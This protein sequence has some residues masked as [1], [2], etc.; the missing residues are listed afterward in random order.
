MDVGN[1][2]GIIIQARFASTRLPGKLFRTFYEEKKLIDVFLDNIINKAGKGLP[3]VLATSVNKK[4]DLF[5]QVA[6]NHKVEFFRGSE[7]DVLQRTIDAAKKFGIS[8]VIRVCADNPV[9]D[10]EGTLKL[11]KSHHGNHA[12]YSG[13]CLQDGTPSIKTHLG[14]WGEVVELDAL[15][16]AAKMTS[17]KLYREHVTNFIYGNKDIFRIN[18]VKAPPLL[19]N[20]KDIRLT[21][22]EIDDFELMRQIYAELKK[23]EY[24]FRLED[25][26]E[27]I[28]GNPGYLKTMKNQIDKN[29]K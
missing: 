19:Y 12:D 6:L 11:L 20:R 14:L 24:Y 17:L 10:I 25:V 26:V 4:D 29:K 27:I 22:D 9:Y 28:D 15:E 7:D 1:K 18:L 8:T 2:D 16:K 13:Y 23:R 21:V 3:V 5:E